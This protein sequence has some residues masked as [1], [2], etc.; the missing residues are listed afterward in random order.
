V[1]SYKPEVREKAIES[2]RR[3]VRG[4]AVSAGIPEDRMPEVKVQD[5]FTPALYNDPTLTRRLGGV[6]KTWLSA[7]RVRTVDPAM[8][9]ED[10]SEYGRTAEKV[11]LFDLWVG[12]V[13]AGTDPANAPGLHSNR[14]APELKPA[15]ETAVTALAAEVLELL[16]RG[17]QEAIVN[18]EAEAWT[19]RV[20][21]AAHGAA[22]EQREASGLRI[23]DKGPIV[24]LHWRGLEDEIAAEAVAEE[25][26][27]QA[28]SQGLVIHRGRSVIELR[29]PVTS[30]KGDA[31]HALL[32]GVEI[33][34]ALYVGDDRTDLDAFR[35]L[36]ALQHEGRLS[37]ILCVGVRSEQTPSELLAEAD[38][39]VDGTEGVASL[40][41]ALIG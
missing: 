31:I 24:A 30:N 1:R 16:P 39:L 3:I 15:L 19:E 32:E 21:A 2:I 33:D 10:F 5:E 9:G 7:D 28:K 11:P 40:L 37:E 18:A 38:L 20:H 14:F 13:P 29:A 22:V 17:A 26:A 36:R 27:E 4:Q 6:L 35:A 25:I 8:G 34:H 23:E 41:S 12:A